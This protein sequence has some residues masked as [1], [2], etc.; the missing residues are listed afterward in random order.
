MNWICDEPADPNNDPNLDLKAKHDFFMNIRQSFG[1]TALLL[2]GGGT[3]GALSMFPC[4]FHVFTPYDM[5]KFLGL[6]HIGV[7]KCLHEAQLLP[8]IISGASSGSIMASL[9]CTKTN[10]E[11]PL[12]FDPSLVRLVS[13]YKNKCVSFNQHLLFL[14]G[15]I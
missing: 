5:Y 10:D 3:L 2:S 7:I 14:L 9:V 13:C 8:R 6:N 15:C 4:A 1:R 11:L 12:M